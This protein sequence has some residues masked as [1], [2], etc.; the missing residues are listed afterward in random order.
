[1]RQTELTLS[2]KDRNALTQWR[3]KGLR[4]ART[5]NRAHILAA[6]DDKVP[7][8]MICRVLGIGRTAIW[9]EPNAGPWCCWNKRRAAAAGSS[10]SVAKRSA[11]C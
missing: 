7:E 6:L 4:Q 9:R 8:S 10:I 1:M 11:G 3:S 2:N 5:I